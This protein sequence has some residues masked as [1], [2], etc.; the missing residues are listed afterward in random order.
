MKLALVLL[1]LCNFGFMAVMWR[2]WGALGGVTRKFL[3]LISLGAF[4]LVW[5][6]GVLG[7]GL[8][9]T[10]KVGFCAQC[11]VMKDYVKSLDVDDNEPLSAVH[12]QNNWV[13]KATA[14][15]ACHTQYTM[16][17][18]VRAKF[19]GLNHLYVYYIKGAPEKI[20]LYAQYDNRE[21]L[22]CHEPSR[23]YQKLRKHNVPER[24]FQKLAE[25][26][27]SCLAKG[28]HDLAHLI[29]KE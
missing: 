15:Y 14:C 13:P 24:M 8:E 28:C 29:E 6:T 2:E 25:G 18:P 27:Q 26:K 3:A 7:H 17:G 9:E 22:R 1:A 12:Y 10:Q 19:Q 4:P 5:G 16:F 11:H 20:K 21:C 23:K